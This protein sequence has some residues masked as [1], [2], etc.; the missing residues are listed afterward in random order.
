MYVLAT[1]HRVEHYY[2][3]MCEVVALS[4]VAA[5]AGSC[6]CAR[7][8]PDLFESAKFYFDRGR[9]RRRNAPPTTYLLSHYYILKWRAI[10]SKFSKRF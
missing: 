1:N 6:R 4:V 9:A 2:R 7:C 8:R 5:G 3:F 10:N